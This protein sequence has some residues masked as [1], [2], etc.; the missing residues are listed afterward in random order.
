MAADG[1][2]PTTVRPALHVGDEIAFAR[3]SG[4]DAAPSTAT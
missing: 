2:V 1:G 3:I 4:V